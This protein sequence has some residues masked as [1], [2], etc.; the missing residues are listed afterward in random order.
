MIE[1]I[2]PPNTLS[3]RRR[4]GLAKEVKVDER[5]STMERCEWKDE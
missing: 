1:A 2:L 3:R 4:I 5:T